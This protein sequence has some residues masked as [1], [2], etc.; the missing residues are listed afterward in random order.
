[1]DNDDQSVEE[2][3]DDDD[4]D[5]EE[6][7]DEEEAE[8]PTSLP[9]ENNEISKL[10]EMINSNHLLTSPTVDELDDNQNRSFKPFRDNNK[11]ESDENDNDDNQSITSSSQKMST[12]S[13]DKEYVRAKVKQTLKKKL[14][15]QHRRLCTKGESALVTAQKRDHRET[16]QL[17]LE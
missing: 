7:K 3:D 13:I 10:T 9:N 8:E 6:E 17:H 1:M 12:L 11:E 16:I 15:Q 5:E 4:G 14:K 2:E